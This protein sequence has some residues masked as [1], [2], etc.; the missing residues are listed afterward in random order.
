MLEWAKQS[1]RDRAASRTDMIMARLPERIMAKTAAAVNKALDDFVHV[2]CAHTH[3][4][5]N[6]AL[7]TAALCGSC[8]AQR[9]C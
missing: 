1:K 6:D 2:R 3:S 4:T 9:T 8:M 7:P 5:R